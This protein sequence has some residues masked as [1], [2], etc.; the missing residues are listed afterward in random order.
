MQYLT[1]STS[2]TFF[3]C[4]DLKFYPETVID[5]TNHYNLYNSLFQDLK[6]FFFKLHDEKTY[7]LKN[8][9]EML[10]ARKEANKQAAANRQKHHA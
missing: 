1:Y 10:A 6:H 3:R 9:V 5:P 7:K 2:V 4:L 8:H